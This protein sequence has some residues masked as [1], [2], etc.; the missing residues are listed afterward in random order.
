MKNLQLNG[1]RV[2]SFKEIEDVSG[3]GDHTDFQ[4]LITLL[5]GNRLSSKPKPSAPPTTTPPA[6]IAPPPPAV[7]TP[8]S[9][10][11]LSSFW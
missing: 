2:L 5:F 10:T 11:R 8:F 6:Q 7:I 9:V 4:R 3:G 1:M